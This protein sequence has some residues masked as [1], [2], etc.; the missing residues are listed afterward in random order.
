MSMPPKRVIGPRLPAAGKPAVI[1]SSFMSPELCDLFT[2]CEVKDHDWSDHSCLIAH[3]RGGPDA[4]LRFPWSK[5]DPMPW[6]PQRQAFAMPQF[7]DPALV[8]ADYRFF[9]SQVEESN[10]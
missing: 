10:C 7:A 8:D 2:H 4:L 1:F 5:P 3:F 9:W 6:M